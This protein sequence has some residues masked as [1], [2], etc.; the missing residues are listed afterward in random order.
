MGAGDVG[1]VQPGHEAGDT[2]AMLKRP[3][4]SRMTFFEARMPHISDSLEI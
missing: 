2:D 3:V 1:P 4:F